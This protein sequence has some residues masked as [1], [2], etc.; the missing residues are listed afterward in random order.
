MSD[1]STIWVLLA[2]GGVVALMVLSTVLTLA[3][4]PR[5]R[6]GQPPQLLLLAVGLAV[7]LVLGVVAT[8]LFLPGSS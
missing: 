8:L 6:T 2:L 4:Q 5:A 7:L 3:R 1:Q